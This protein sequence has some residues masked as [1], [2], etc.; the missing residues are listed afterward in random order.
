[1]A[2]TGARIDGIIIGNTFEIQR[3]VSG[4]ADGR[5]VA[6]ARFLLKL[7]EDD[8]DV[9]ALIDNVVTTALTSK[10]QITDTGADGEA[11]FI[12]TLA[13]ASIAAQIIIGTGNAA[14]RWTAVKTGNA[15][16]KIT[17]VYV[18]PSASSQSLAI[19]VSSNAITVSLATD[20]GGT[21]TTVAN[22]IIPA[23]VASTAASALVTVLATG[24][25]LSLVSAVAAT[26]LAGGN[27]GTTDLDNISYSYAIR[28]TLD[29]GDVFPV[30]SGS[31]IV[32]DVTD[33]GTKTAATTGADALQSSSERT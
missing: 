32:T 23:I 16:N 17:V 8:T 6:S 7:K 18:D 2:I 26:S 15:G 13:S 10:G 24:T 11:D 31:A 27:G 22:D 1:V 5:T 30:E 28:I 33:V 21:I 20:G 4:I 3:N 29:N 12:F 9:N 19:T 25:G 14:L